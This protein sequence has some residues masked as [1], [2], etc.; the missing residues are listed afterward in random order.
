MFEY[1]KDNDMDLLSETM[2][3]V[4][5]KMGMFCQNR[6]MLESFEKMGAQVDFE[7]EN[8]KFP[9]RLVQAFIDKIK[10]ENS[11]DVDKNFTGVNRKKTTAKFEAPPPPCILHQLATFLYDD[12]QGKKRP[13]NKQDFINVT[14]FGDV[15]HPECG[16]GHS[17]SLLDVPAPVEPL[18]AA[19]LLYEYAHK[20]IG[21]Y[22]Q[23]VRQID[24]L[25]EIEALA[26][27]KDPYWHYLANIAFAS[28][29][30]L[31]KDIAD[32]FV[33]MVKSGDYPAKVYSMGVSGLSMPVTAAGS[34]VL[35]GAELV[36]LWISARSLNPNISLSGTVLTGTMNMHNEW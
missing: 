14:K 19:L 4:L 28:P 34:V 32:R 5:E 29:L 6:E 10:K 16:V 13:G 3:E 11:P 12:E 25:K 30:R 1:L 35:T 22:V 36:A 8:A 31:G 7:K 9:K 23:D 33:Y 24:Y 21:V 27:I 18:E 26:G 2:L 15:L 17:L 20:P